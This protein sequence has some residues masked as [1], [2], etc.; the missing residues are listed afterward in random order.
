[1]EAADS[2]T[3]TGVVEKLSAGRVEYGALR[4][5]RTAAITVVWRYLVSHAGRWFACGELVQRGSRYAVL[6]WDGEP[7]TTVSSVR[8]GLEAVRS[9]Y[10][11]IAMGSAGP[12]DS[13]R[14]RPLRPRGGGSSSRV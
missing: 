14:P 7:I 5:H 9:F 4:A 11:D 2:Q 1:M 12:T 10:A 6:G 8:E 3:S 13:L